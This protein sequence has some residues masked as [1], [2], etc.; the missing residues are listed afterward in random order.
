MKMRMAYEDAIKRLLS[1]EFRA[2]DAQDDECAMLMTMLVRHQIER[3][4]AI[5]KAARDVVARWEKSSEGDG[6]HQH[7][8]SALE[9]AL[10]ELR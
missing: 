4:Q 6:Y 10:K 7:E 8:M 5:E 1:M 3:W 2:W 9:S